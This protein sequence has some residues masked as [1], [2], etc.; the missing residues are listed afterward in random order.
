MTIHTGSYLK[1][2]ECVEVRDDDV[3]I[4]HLAPHVLD[5]VNGGFVVW[6]WT[7]AERQLLHPEAAHLKQ[8]VKHQP[9]ELHRLHL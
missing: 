1:V 5:G 8:S 4:L 3:L 7:A 2:E 6:L 9:G